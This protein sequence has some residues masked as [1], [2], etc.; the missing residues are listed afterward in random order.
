MRILY[1][2]AGDG[3]G[4]AVRSAVVIEELLRRG[5]DVRIATSGDSTGYLDE[6]FSGVTEIWGLSVV[7]RDNRINRP[8]TLAS[9]IRTGLAPSG[10]ARNIFKWLQTAKNFDPDLVVSD[11]ELWSATFGAILDTPVIG[12]DNVHLLTRASHPPQITDGLERQFAIENMIIRARVPGAAHYLIP[13]FAGSRPTEPK[14][15]L[16]PPVLRDTILEATPSDGDHVLVYQTSYGTYDLVSVLRQLDAPVKLYGTKGGIDEH[17][18]I[19]NV[20]LCPFDEQKF[21]DDLAS[22]RA[23][24][25]TSGF[26]LI[27]EALHMRKPYFGI[28]VQGQVEQVF[29]SRYVDWLGYGAYSTE[30]DLGAIRHFLGNLSEYRRNLDN[31]QPRDNQE[32]F[33]RLEHLIDR[34]A[35]REVEPAS[36][37]MNHRA[38]E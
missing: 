15:T 10:L 26:T 12:L 34:H 23:V 24:V 4:H 7:T 33:D 6:K 35:R 9:N 28:P 8:L 14:T 36:I 21:V 16:I 5:H 3:L 30:P 37:S 29:N 13:T 31:Y 2:I 17:S 18:Q 1:G 22:C 32:T 20:Q 25:G 19:D 11:L 27:T 38:A